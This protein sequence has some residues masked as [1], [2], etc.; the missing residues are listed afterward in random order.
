MSKV[1]FFVLLLPWVLLPW[2]L[3]LPWVVFFADAS[4]RSDPRGAKSCIRL[5]LEQWEV[6]R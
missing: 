6:I 1:G 2:V 5:L 3:L 4:S